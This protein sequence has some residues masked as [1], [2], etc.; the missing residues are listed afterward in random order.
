M[1]SI[2]KGFTLIEL[3][4][5][6]AI[7]GILAS[8]AL[9]AYREYITTTELSTTFLSVAGIQRAVEVRASR[10]GSAI[11]IT[12]ASNAKSAICTNADADSCWQQRL[13]MPGKPSK[14][15]YMNS[16]AVGPGTAATSVCANGPA[17]PVASSVT[18]GGAIQFVLSGA[19]GELAGTYYM[20]PVVQPSGINWASYS[21]TLNASTSAITAVS[22]NWMNDNL[23]SGS[24]S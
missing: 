10:Y 17:L 14:E 3:M 13:G 24:S 16:L 15:G 18:V 12:G 5:V 20:T 22:C 9:P 6:I 8:V 2:Q 19:A 1:K 11:V 7:I 4:I 23:N 21:T